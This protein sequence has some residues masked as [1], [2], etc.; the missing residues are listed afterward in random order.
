MTREFIQF[1]LTD[2]TSQ[3]LLDWYN[4]TTAPE[5]QYWHTLIHNA[6]LNA[7][8]TFPG[9][10]IY[11]YNYLKKSKPWISRYQ[12]WN[13][14]RGPG[15]EWI[16]RPTGECKGKF[17]H[18]SCAF[19]IGD[20]PALTDTTRPELMA[21]K[22]Y[23]EFQ[24]ATT[25]CLEYW[26]WEIARNPPHTLNETYYAEFPSVRYQNMKNKNEFVC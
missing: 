14:R 18:Y 19:G 22:V 24:P 12:I 1:V 15:G 9:S 10:C 11:F 2:P 26:F 23:E 20:V 8:G 13:H 21:H 6:H 16:R 17:V 7:P 4:Y 5:E 3:R 25:F